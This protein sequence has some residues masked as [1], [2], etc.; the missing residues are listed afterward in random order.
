M[1]FFKSAQLGSF[2]NATVRDTYSNGHKRHSATIAPNIYTFIIFDSI[3]SG[4]LN[5]L[6]DEIF[7]YLNLVDKFET[8]IVYLVLYGRS[9]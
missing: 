1:K 2:F 9:Y 7:K 5:S 4:R 3:I 6:W 8:L